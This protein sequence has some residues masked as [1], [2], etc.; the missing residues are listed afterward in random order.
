[1][2]L[3]PDS[4]VQLPQPPKDMFFHYELSHGFGGW[5]KINFRVCINTFS[6]KLSWASESDIIY[7]EFALSVRDSKSRFFYRR[8]WK[9]L[10]IN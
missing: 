9:Q 2:F 3:F 1:M 6:V 4:E 5:L 7:E 8:F 10:L